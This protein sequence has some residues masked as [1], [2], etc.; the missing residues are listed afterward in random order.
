M[1]GSERSILL[2]GGG[3]LALVLVSVTIALTLGPSAVEDYPADSPAGALQRYLGALASGDNTAALAF[4]SQRAQGD[5]QRSGAPP[6]GFIC[7]NAAEP[8]VR[9]V[10]V[11][12]SGGRATLRLEIEQ[13]NRSLLGFDRYTYERTVMLVRE[14]DP[15]A[16]KIDETWLCL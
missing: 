10:G 9:V 12:E 13:Y 14:G 2:I 8:R 3:V 4:V 16:W 11:D 6:G 15:A 1:R 7:P 5:L